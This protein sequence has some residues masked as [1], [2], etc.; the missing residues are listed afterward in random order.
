LREI[1]KGDAELV[2]QQISLPMLRSTADVRIPREGKGIAVL[3]PENWKARGSPVVGGI[4]AAAGNRDFA[5]FCG[6]LQIAL[7]TR[8][9][10]RFARAHERC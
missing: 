2:G 4:S 5:Y 10:A 6:D 3:L 1:I 7:G 9:P 8:T